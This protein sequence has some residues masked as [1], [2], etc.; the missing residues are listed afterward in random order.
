M[1]KKIQLADILFEYFLPV[2]RDFK[3]TGAIIRNLWKSAAVDLA[4]YQIQTTQANI[5]AVDHIIIIMSK[6]CVFVVVP[7]FRFFSH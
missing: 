4:L 5:A 6:L 2:F 1:M 3:Q 7:T